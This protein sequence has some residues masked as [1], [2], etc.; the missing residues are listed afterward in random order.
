MK[1]KKE[2][3]KSLAKPDKK[4]IVSEVTHRQRNNPDS[5]RERDSPDLIT[6]THK[7]KNSKKIQPVN[8]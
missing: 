3:K 6:L 8:H 5:E 7:F 2:S 4:V 1:G